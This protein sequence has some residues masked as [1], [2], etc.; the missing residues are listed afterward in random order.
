MDLYSVRNLLS[1]GKTIYDINLK[2]TFYARVSTDKDEQ[3]NSLNNQISYYTEFINKCPNWTY[4]EGYYD[5]GITGTS[6]NKRE[7]F[8]RMIEDGKKGKFDLIITK[9]ISRFSRNTLDSIKYTQELLA[10]G[11]GVFFQNDSINTL[12]S[13]SELRLTIMSSIA[14]EEVRK[15]SERVRFG[16]RRSIADGKVLGNDNIYG[17]TKK[18]GKL[19]IEP[20]EAK[21]VERIFE[22]Y[23]T[24]LGLRAIGGKLLEE[25]ITNRN[26]KEFGYSTIKRIIQNPKYKGYYCG[27]KSHKVAYNLDEIKKLDQSEWVMYKDDE[28]VPQIIDEV[29]WERA[30]A[31]FQK[32]S[33]EVKNK[34]TSYTNKFVYSRKI[35]CGEHDV[36]YYHA[37]YKYKSGVK[38]IWQCKRYSEKGLEGCKLPIIYQDE[39]D[40]IV[41]QV[42]NSLVVH[43]TDIIADILDLFSG[44]EVQNGLKEKLGALEK[45]IKDTLKRKDR[46]LDLSIDGTISQNEFKA[47]NEKFNIEIE[48]LKMEIDTVK[49]NI[50]ENTLALSSIEKLRNL[51]N[52]EL[53][54]DT[55]IT[56]ELV[57]SIIEKITVL[58][59]STKESI[60]LEVKINLF[61]EPQ[62]YN[63]KRAENPV[64]ERVSG[65]FDITSFCSPLYT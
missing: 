59:S 11:I 35:F 49:N 30:N 21:I 56:T 10:A 26:G 3:L 1:M 9:E 45:Q 16:F 14:Q 44:D 4:V 28:N 65:D 37:T 18:D 25:G 17:Y 34:E 43:K 32:R 36:A 50:N 46:L 40:E 55:K 42:V 12:Q 47:R 54:D 61:S 38:H 29:I 22:L 58:K 60:D 6:A 51:I 63:V 31:I 57:E 8:L 33:K 27:N 24:G 39:L 13:D 53:K 19:I 48:N 52:E 62:S 7:N 5:E 20:K 23:L 15:L 2:V 41:R 64:I